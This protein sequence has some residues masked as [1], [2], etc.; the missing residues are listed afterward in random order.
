[1]AAKLEE[2]S[3]ELAALGG[4]AAQVAR[5][6]A[7]VHIA[8]QGTSSSIIQHIK[9][10]VCVRDPR[11]PPEAESCAERKFKLS[12]CISADTDPRGDQ[13]NA[14]I[15]QLAMADIC[16]GFNHT[17]MC[18]GQAGAGKSTR[19]FG[20]FAWPASS[21]PGPCCLLTAITQHVLDFCDARIGV[22]QVGLSFWEI[23]NDEVVDL[24]AAHQP[25]GST[26][27]HASPA[28]VAV[29]GTPGLSLEHTAVR[30]DSLAD[31]DTAAAYAR[32]RSVN[33]G[34]CG[35]RRDLLTL[36]PNR[37]HAFA[38]LL[39][40]NRQEG[41]MALLHVV[42][43]I[44]SQPLHGQHRAESLFQPRPARRASDDCSR[45]RA[46]Q[47]LLS[48]SRMLTQLASGC[49]EGSAS[50]SSAHM[51]DTKLTTALYPIVAGNSRMTLVAAVAP[52]AGSYLDTCNTLRLASRAQAITTRMLRNH[53]M[54]PFLDIPPIWEALPAEALEIVQRA[55]HALDR[56]ADVS[57]IVPGPTAAPDAEGNDSRTSSARGPHA[58]APAELARPLEGAGEPGSVS[59]S[60]ADVCEQ[61]PSLAHH[62]RGAPHGKVLRAVCSST[63]R[64]A[65][66]EVSGDAVPP[67]A[68]GDVGME[69]RGASLTQ[70]TAR[71]DAM[72]AAGWEPQLQPS[73][74]QP[75]AE[76]GRSQQR[77]TGS[78]GSPTQLQADPRSAQALHVHPVPYPAATGVCYGAPPGSDAGEPSLPSTDAGAGD[79]VCQKG[80]GELGGRG[81]LPAA[82]AGAGDLAVPLSP[83]S[84]R[85]EAA[86]EEYHRLMQ[87]IVA[88][89]EMAG[90]ATSRHHGAPC[91]GA[92]AV[93]GIADAGMHGAEGRGTGRSSLV[94]VGYAARYR[95]NRGARVASGGDADRSMAA[96]STAQAGAGY[97]GWLSTGRV[98]PPVLGTMLARPPPH[99][100]AAAAAP[101]GS[102]QDTQAQTA[103]AAVLGSM[104]VGAQHRAPL[105]P[106]ER[107]RS[108][109]PDGSLESGRGRLSRS[110]SP[111]ALTMPLAEAARAWPG[112]GENWV[113]Q[114]WAAPAV[115]S[116]ACSYSM[117]NACAARR[118]V[119][120]DA[121][122][123]MSPE[124]RHVRPRSAGPC[125]HV[126]FREGLGPPEGGSPSPPR[127][128]RAHCGDAV[129]CSMA[130]AP[131]DVREL[132]E[133]RE[134]LLDTLERE[135]LQLHASKQRV[136]ELEADVQEC[137]MT[138]EVRLDNERLRRVEL[139]RLLTALQAGSSMADVFARYE[140]DLDTS[141]S[142]VRELK[143][144]NTALLRAQHRDA[145]AAAAAT[146]E[147]AHGDGA[148]C[149]GAEGAAGGGCVSS[150]GKAAVCPEMGLPKDQRLAMLR[151]QLRRALLERDAALEEIGGFRKKERLHVLKQKQAALAIAR[152]TELEK[153]AARKEREAAQRTREAAAF[154]DEALESRRRCSRVE[155][156][157]AALQA[158]CHTLEA[159]RKQAQGEL[160]ALRSAR[161]GA[162]LIAALP[163][164]PTGTGATLPASVLSPKRATAPVEGALALLRTLRQAPLPVAAQKLAD[165]LEA[166]VQVVAKETSVRKTRERMLIE[167][168][169]GSH[170]DS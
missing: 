33:W 170:A 77:T 8:P 158:R 161:G 13:F 153:S 30:I 7:I 1:M 112:A 14:E 111:P 71:G 152:V 107:W 39:V 9:G 6:K 148:E 38:R 91:V 101:H 64:R 50:S 136:R 67:A 143:A 17:I 106:E 147:P 80:A 24:L 44:G 119:P 26:A 94:A 52:D 129:A 118:S 20:R 19:L 54:G 168:V 27:T 122:T 68:D 116:A 37:G 35:P 53:S 141:A 66:T 127:G 103:D 133:Q 162:E 105:V 98:S 62:S 140:R 146:P 96:P 84:W 22:F 59:A 32:T 142:E 56:A 93:A 79:A 123:C 149:T 88:P 114:E 130:A 63:Q 109:A 10:D 36:L 18:M 124:L 159:G 131:A 100:G 102:R 49:A 58:H 83:P 164:L 126:R 117:T 28:R 166:V 61:E 2:L 29:R 121:V 78:A 165:K 11:A 75:A 132:M 47:D 3:A 99:G 134:A 23:V 163:P 110:L 144:A 167:F 169:E 65:E 150:M 48:L 72:H 73:A 82:E 57:D 97:A 154:S 85:D 108:F 60:A 95:E 139:E 16:K 5:H 113:G 70:D 21:H 120:L 90:L 55:Q 41:W 69:A 87:S 156:E 15:C 92:R 86:E 4:G 25:S 135:R 125:S 128:S 155:E 160:Q 34:T 151:R 138:Y 45:R 51:R 43:L 46:S 76:H 12:S 40:H 157:L 145:F 89:L 115:A 104:H 137:S 74:E 31:A 81:E 42:D